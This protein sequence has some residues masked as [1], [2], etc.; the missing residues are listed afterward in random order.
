MTDRNK[1]VLKRLYIAVY[2][3]VSELVLV[4]R[5]AWHLLIYLEDALPFHLPRKEIKIRLDQ[6]FAGL[7]TMIIKGF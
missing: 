6:M 1:A 5:R 2:W 3:V 7:V 4:T